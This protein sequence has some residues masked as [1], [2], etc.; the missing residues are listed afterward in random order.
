MTH[1]RKSKHGY[2]L[3][4]SILVGAMALSG[5]LACF[6]QSSAAAERVA[7]KPCRFFTSENPVEPKAG[8]WKTWI[9]ESP[10]QIVVNAPPYAPDEIAEL[11]Q[12]ERTRDASVIDEVYYWDAGGPSY[13][14]NQI[15]LDEV[16]RANLNNNRIGRVMALLNV[17]IY[18]AMVAAWE[19][20]YLHQRPRPSDCTP[21]L[22]TV[23]DNPES[24]SYPSGYAVAAGA[25]ST[26]L[27]HLFPASAQSLNRMA[28]QAAQSRLNAGVNYRS[29]VTAGLE[30]GRT[31]GA[32]V[33]NYARNDG[34]NAVF[35]GTIPTGVCNWKGTNPVEPLGGTWRPWVLASGNE[36]RP[37]APPSCD[38]AKFAEELAEV[39]DF[40]RPTPT[41]AASFPTTRAAYFWQG[42]VNQIW[43]DVLTTKLFE[44]KLDANPP[45]A[46]RAYALFHIAAYDA[47]IAVWDAKYTYWSIRP[48]QA[49]PVS[50]RFL[51]YP[52]TPA[53]HQDMHCT[54][55]VMRRS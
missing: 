2:T 55:G 37:P 24:P 13:R 25:A 39:R 53:I 36:L 42:F 44:Y 15:A 4:I 3:I 54:M 47:A 43:N 23:I 9:L 29:D 1:F 48:S 28:E 8:T 49:D 50:E 19:W 27:A 41:N 52:I 45:R 32:L 34:S 12:L 20:K 51:Q 38:S 10:R 11:R 26:V 18:D 30:L 14:W 31:V 40:P 35:T 33:V 7:L 16:T 21:S 17:A 5:P 6:A 46:A 22:T